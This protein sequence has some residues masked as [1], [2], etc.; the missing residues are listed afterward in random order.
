M[1]DLQTHATDE[2]EMHNRI[3]SRMVSYFNP[4]KI[5][6]KPKKCNVFGVKN[7]TFGYVSRLPATTISI[8]ELPHEQ[9]QHFELRVYA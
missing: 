9:P 6:V 3:S 4:S 1:N 7:S 5:K 8:L 2:P